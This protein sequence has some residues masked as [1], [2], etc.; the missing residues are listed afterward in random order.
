[1]YKKNI[2]QFLFYLFCGK[3]ETQNFKIMSYLDTRD[4]I[5]ER[6][7]LKQ[8]ILDSFLE[9]FP[10]Y[11]DMTDTFEDIRFEEEE[12]ENWKDLWYTELEVIEAINELENE[13]GDEWSYGVT[14]IEE[15]DFEEYCEDF[16]KDCGY[17]R[18]DTPQLIQNNIDW[19]GIADDMKQDY[20]EVSFRGNNYLFR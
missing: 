18:D 3:I 5:E 13:V 14:L 9:E 20:L 17:I 15:D 12:I 19:S 4:L 11:E 1:L 7:T 8:N 6:D 16:V 2:N 10:Q